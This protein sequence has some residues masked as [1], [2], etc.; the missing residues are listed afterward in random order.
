MI[1]FHVPPT[2]TTRHHHIR[3][4]PRAFDFSSVP[5]EFAPRWL[6][7]RSWGWYIKYNTFIPNG[8]SMV[9]RGHVQQTYPKKWVTA[10]EVRIRHRACI[11]CPTTDT[12]DASWKFQFHL[13]SQWRTPIRFWMQSSRTEC[14]D[15]DI[16]K[17]LS[18]VCDIFCTTSISDALFLEQITLEYWNSRGFPPTTSL[19]SDVLKG[20]VPGMASRW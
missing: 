3:G 2:K 13:G 1:P 10:V 8:R 20:Y 16:W 18:Q 5:E 19:V 4:F 12:R 14:I 7:D 15:E 9:V 11:G 17:T 6:M